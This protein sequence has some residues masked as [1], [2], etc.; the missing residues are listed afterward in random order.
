[1]FGFGIAEVD[2]VMRE[3]CSLSG[4]NYPTSKKTGLNTEQDKMS[5]EDILK[6]CVDWNHQ[7]IQNEIKSIEKEIKDPQE[8]ALL[9]EYAKLKEAK[10]N[11]ADQERSLN[12]KI[13]LYLA[14]QRGVDSVNKSY[15]GFGNNNALHDAVRKFKGKA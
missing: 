10:E 11:L 8:K 4:M 15:A 6:R 13:I 14:K 3:K 2:D 7:V 1:I 12:R 9:I 5:E